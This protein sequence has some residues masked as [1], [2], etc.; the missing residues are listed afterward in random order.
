M[1][2]FF[3][4]IFL[5]HYWKSNTCLKYQKEN[6]FVYT[7]RLY[8]D[9][10]LA[11]I[12]E[13]IDSVFVFLK[14]SNLTINHRIDLVFFRNLSESEKYH[15]ISSDLYGGLNIGYTCSFLSYDFSRK[16]DMSIIVHELV[17]SY[18]YDK[19]GRSIDEKWKVEGFAEF[20]SNP[21][22]PDIY[23]LNNKFM[24]R[25]K[26]DIDVVFFYFLGR[27]RTD[28]LLR[29]KGIPEN[30]YW[31]TEYDTDK[32]DDEIREALQNGEYRAFEQ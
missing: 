24:Q 28:Y 1:L 2:K 10:E 5:S 9:E 15:S 32:L 31:D 20:H 29:H 13:T 27:L 11:G 17:H 3:A 25:T 12:H 14:N 6:I 7:S 18:E 22:C 4:P 26:E 19:Y 8:N 30:E 23:E 21:F 16:Q